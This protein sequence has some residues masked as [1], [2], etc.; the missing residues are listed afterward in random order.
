MPS[1]ATVSSCCPKIMHL[2]VRLHCIKKSLNAQTLKNILLSVEEMPRLFD[3]I[4]DKEYKGPVAAYMFF[5]A[6]KNA[7]IMAYF[8][9]N[10]ALIDKTAKALA[11]RVALKHANYLKLECLM[12][13]PAANDLEIIQRWCQHSLD[14]M[15]GGSLW[16]TANPMYF[17]CKIAPTLV[18]KD[19][20]VALLANSARSAKTPETLKL[21]LAQAAL[22]GA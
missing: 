8:A 6:H 4:D 20:R 18:F 16:V 11:C 21:L 13:S 15:H 9:K 2:L 17:T 19:K 3:A 7:K 5:R 22:L 10:T 1:Q 12:L 14:S